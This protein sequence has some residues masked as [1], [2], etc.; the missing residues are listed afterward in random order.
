[1]HETGIMDDLRHVPGRA[2]TGINHT[3]RAPVFRD[4]DTSRLPLLGPQCSSHQNERAQTERRSLLYTEDIGHRLAS[5]EGAHIIGA[6]T[7]SFLRTVVTTRSSL[8]EGLAA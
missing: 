1:M 5:Y 7:A 6:L 2:V 3:P 4:A 8:V